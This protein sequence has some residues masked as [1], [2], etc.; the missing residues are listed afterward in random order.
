MT[1]SR[2]DAIH[3]KYARILTT[4]GGTRY[5][6]FAVIVFKSLEENRVVIR[7]VRL[8]GASDVAHQF[9]VSIQ[10]NGR[11]RR[12]IIE[13]KDFDLSGQRVGLEIIR[14]FW[15]VW[16]DTKANEA[17]VLTC[18]GFTSDAAKFAKAKGIKLAVLRAFEDSDWE[19]RFRTIVLQIIAINRSNYEMR[20]KM[21][22]GLQ[23]QRL[24]EAL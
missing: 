12:V 10:S 7:D 19:G 21:A 16:S 6:R 13:C 18:T 1:N 14:N 23:K 20:I 11:P 3:D 4:K 5:E 15:A 22:G 9:D 24:D 17:I 8:I 2:Y